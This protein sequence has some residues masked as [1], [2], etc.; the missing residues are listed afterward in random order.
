[1][2]LE[3]DVARKIFIDES[4]DLLQEMENALL[5]LEESPD[6]DATINALFRAAHTI[7]GSAGIIGLEEVEKFTHKVESVLEKVRQGS[8]RI[9]S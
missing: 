2:D 5:N 9:D 6:D 8:L 1:M 7:K 3:M 4:S